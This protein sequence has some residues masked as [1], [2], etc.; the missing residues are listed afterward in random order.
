MEKEKNYKIY[1]V[2]SQTYS[3]LARTI[4]SI[5]REK[6]SH[7]SIAFDENCD[8]MYSFGRKWKHFPFFPR[9]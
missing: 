4:K 5:T 7:V 2:L 1:I 6:Y 3:M 9:L 8:E